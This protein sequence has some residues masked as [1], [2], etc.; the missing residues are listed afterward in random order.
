MSVKLLF[1]SLVSFF[2]RAGK[3]GNTIIVPEG[4]ITTKRP[5]VYRGKFGKYE[6][7]WYLD[8]SRK[9]E[10]VGIWSGGLSVELRNHCKHINYFDAVNVA[11]DKNLGL[12]KNGRKFF[13]ER[14][15]FNET[16]ITLMKNGVYAE[17]WYEDG[18]YW[19]SD[20]S[21]MWFARIFLMK[22]KGCRGTDH[23]NTLHRVRFVRDLYLKDL[24]F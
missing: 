18:F 9:D 21:S 10:V 12:P 13:K 6:V 14:A 24:D 8:P 1:K 5:V 4:C 2:V 17:V 22:G 19:T 16:A 20:S 7:L 11:K 15:A 3:E 23:K